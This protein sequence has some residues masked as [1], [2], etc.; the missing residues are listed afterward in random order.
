MLVG[1]SATAATTTVAVAVLLSW[2]PSLHFHVKVVVPF[3]FAFGENVTL[4]P[5]ILTV[6]FAGLPTI[7]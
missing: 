1:A 2:Y 3:Q 4:D 5:D 7:L 6:A